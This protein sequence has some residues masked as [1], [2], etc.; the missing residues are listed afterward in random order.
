MSLFRQRCP[1]PFHH[2]L[3]YA[4]ERRERLRD[5]ERKA[6]QELGLDV[7]QYSVNDADQHEESAQR[8]KGVFLDATKHTRQR[9]LL[10]RRASLS[11]F[12]V[13]LLL[14]LLVIA[15]VILFVLMAQ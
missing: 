3:V 7:E 14:L 9:N 13:V 1:R 8:L 5:I 10:Q 15:L 2:R 11:R 12:N 4:N 6:R